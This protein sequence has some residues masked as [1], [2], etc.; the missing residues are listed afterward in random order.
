MGAQ[1]KNLVYT[2]IGRKAMEYTQKQNIYSYVK[3]SKEDNM[4]HK[5]LISDLIRGVN[6]GRKPR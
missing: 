6:G 3:F 4:E 5:Y 2:S 1:K